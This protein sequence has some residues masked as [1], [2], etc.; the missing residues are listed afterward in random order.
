MDIQISAKTSDSKIKPRK[1]PRKGSD[2]R[3]KTGSRERNVA[4]P[5]GEEHSRVAKGNGTF[6]K[7]V[8]ISIITAS[9]I[10]IV[11]FVANDVTVV[12][13]AD[14]AAIPALTKII[15]DC[16]ENVMQ[17]GSPVAVS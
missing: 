8:D 15:W 1:D 4:H 17:S 11:Y 14:D 13:V 16:V 10:G 9:G 2:A 5:N 12:G 6:R 7:I 3:R